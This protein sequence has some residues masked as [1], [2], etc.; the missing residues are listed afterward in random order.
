MKSILIHIPFWVVASLLFHQT[1][2]QIESSFDHCLR[3]V[4]LT[5]IQK[6]RASVLDRQ[7]RVLRSQ[8]SG[9]ELSHW[10]E[11]V[12][13]PFVSAE[14]RSFFSHGGYSI[15][16]MLRAFWINLTSW[17]FEQG[18][19]TITQQTVKLNYLSQVKTIDRKL[20]ELLLSISI[21]QEY[22]KFEILAAYL[23][24]LYFG[25]GYYGIQ[26]AAQGFYGVSGK[27]LNLNQSTLL[28]SV[29]RAPSRMN[30]LRKRGRLQAK[31]G[32]IMFS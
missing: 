21:E 1:Y 18:G 29:I 28:A 9:A 10:P 26:E 22:D 31:R 6:E 23:N 15:K 2:K 27:D 17:G 11:I 3:Y 5:P 20:V 4:Q 24:S 25:S 12:W 32:K 30:L 14:D 8:L 16:G 19:S 13:Q 7:G